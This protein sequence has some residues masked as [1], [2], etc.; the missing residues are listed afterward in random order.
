MDDVFVWLRIVDVTDEMDVA[1]HGLRAVAL[2]RVRVVD[3]VPVPGLVVRLVA[4]L[5]RVADRN[6]RMD[7]NH[8]KSLVRVLV[9]SNLGITANQN[10]VLVHRNAIAMSPALVPDHAQSRI[11]V[12]VPSPR[13]TNRVRDP[14]RAPVLHDPTQG[15]AIARSRMIS[16]TISPVLHL[17]KITITLR[18]VMKAWRI[19]SKCALF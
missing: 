2:D 9:Q 16:H 1:A 8:L 12:R 11:H 7:R 4:V 3:R 5:S 6:R 14:D 15:L 13:T 18:S 10:H 17:P 19:E